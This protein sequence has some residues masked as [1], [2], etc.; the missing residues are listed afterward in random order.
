MPAVA[1]VARGDGVQSAH[2]FETAREAETFAREWM[3]RNRSMPS[4]ITDANAAH[5]AVKAPNPDGPHDV[6]GMCTVA[7]WRGWGGDWFRGWYSPWVGGA[8]RY[9]KEAF[10]SAE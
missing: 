4:R 10:S 1:I 9:E 6:D 2:R 3:A 8:A 5:V 7:I